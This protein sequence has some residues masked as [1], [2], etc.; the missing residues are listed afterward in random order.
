MRTENVKHLIKKILPASLTEAIV[1]YRMPKQRQK[2]INQWVEAGRPVPPPHQYKQF[3]IE[4]YQ[5]KYQYH[6][7]IETGTF[8]G[9]M[10]DAQK[11]N[12]KQIIS[13]ELGEELWKNAVARFKKYPHIT[14]VK[15]DS[16]KVL[17]GIMKDLE[18]PA[19]FWLDGHYSHGITARGEKD[20]P[21]YE[22]VDAIFK[23]KKLDHVLLI[24]DARD[25]KGKADYPTIHE[26]TNYIKAKDNRYT[27]EVKDD[28]LRYTV[29]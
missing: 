3:V 4:Q 25:F 1:T 8:V 22:E 24:D 11:N 18:E 16:G 17:G 12:F 19:I 6:T 27:V 2:I 14:I 23:Y 21:I 29:G 28:I 26:L 7:L 10:V 5:L 15:G 20:C 9:D 13:I